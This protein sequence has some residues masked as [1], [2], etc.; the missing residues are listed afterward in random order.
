[1]L[2]VVLVLAVGVAVGSAGLLVPDL[3]VVGA[4][5]LFIGAVGGAVLV[6]DRLNEMLTRQEGVP[7][8]EG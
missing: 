2:G 8:T 7:E 1:M 6:G 4:L 5:I 3:Y